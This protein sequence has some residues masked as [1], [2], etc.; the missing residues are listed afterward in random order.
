M[1][2]ING[3]LGTALAVVGAQGA[4]A[5]TVLNTSLPAVNGNYGAGVATTTTTANGTVT[6]VVGPGG[7]ANRA[8][9]SPT[10][11]SWY[12]DS[13]GGNGSVGITKTFTNDANG[14]AYF[15]TVD[16]NSKGDLRYNFAAPVALSSLTSLSYDFY[17]DTS[18]TTPTPFVP[19]VRLDIL[20]DGGFAGSLI[21]EY[22]YQNQLDAP[23]GVWTSLS[24][25]LSSGIF[26]AS[27]AAL[28]PTFA[29]A[30]GGQKTL[31]DWIAANGNSS[32]TV[33]GVSTGVGSGW[34]GGSFSGAVDHV[35]Y[36]FTG[37]PSANFD[38]AVAGVPEP[39][40]WALMI[41]GFGMVGF[42]SRRRRQSARITYA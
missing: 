11:G 23:T 28:G 25:N 21:L 22:K 14:A 12:Q 1:K 7:G 39:A 26:W 19:T 29:S 3:L 8:S 16:G 38:F 32:L 27:N 15:S 2:M 42:A 36:N 35:A 40:S 41:G 6:T 37:G 5:Q 33:F 34:N 17:R 13:V 24:A 9:A 18:S 4:T 31:T 10:T 20:K 30:N